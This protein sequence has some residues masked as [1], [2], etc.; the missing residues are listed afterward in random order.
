MNGSIDRSP[1]A[2]NPTS[3]EWHFEIRGKN[4]DSAHHIQCRV[5][6]MGFQS[7]CGQ[8]CQ[9]GTVLGG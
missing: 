5:L 2:L 7:R 3:V 6:R 8:F 1:A 4:I 9:H